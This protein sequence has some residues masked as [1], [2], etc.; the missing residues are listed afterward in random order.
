[1]PA[2]KKFSKRI[3]VRGYI[4]KS[5]GIDTVSSSVLYSVPA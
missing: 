4:P 2:N 3:G 1:M 5:G